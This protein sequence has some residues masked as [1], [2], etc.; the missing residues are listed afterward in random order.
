ME[1]LERGVF[2]RGLKVRKNVTKCGKVLTGGLSCCIT[3]YTHLPHV[4]ST[5][6]LVIDVR[7]ARDGTCVEQQVANLPSEAQGSTHS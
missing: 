1:S 4:F 3:R 5:K 7:P 2:S 6:D